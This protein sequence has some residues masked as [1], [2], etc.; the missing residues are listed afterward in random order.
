MQMTAGARCS[1]LKEQHGGRAA[2]TEQ[3]PLLMSY[4]CGK[5]EGFLVQIVPLTSTIRITGITGMHAHDKAASQEATAHILHTITIILSVR[6]SLPGT[7]L[8]L[9]QPCRLL[10]AC[11]AQAIK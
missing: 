2:S 5:R 9:Q 10:V 4:K 6:R 3:K 1:V 8:S 7:A 11:L